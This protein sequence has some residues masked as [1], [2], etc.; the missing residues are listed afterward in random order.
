MIVET[1]GNPSVQDF[2]SIGYPRKTA[3]NMIMRMCNT[4]REKMVSYAEDVLSFLRK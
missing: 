1:K 3:E 2:M 4:S